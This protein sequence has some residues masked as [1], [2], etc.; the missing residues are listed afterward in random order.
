MVGEQQR[1]EGLKIGTQQPGIA[2]ALFTGREMPKN[3]AFCEE[4]H[5]SENCAN[6][7][8]VNEHKTV[9][10]KEARC[11]SYL[12]KGHRSFKYMLKVDCEI[13]KYKHHCT[14]RPTL[15]TSK[16]VTPQPSAPSYALH[17]ALQDRP[18]KPLDPILISLGPFK[19]RKQYEEG[20]KTQ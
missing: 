20:H 12:R 1:I 3:F 13:C 16:E 9:F 14:I 4:E 7:K 8:G 2:S 18:S 11:F 6:V 15:P 5:L 10:I 17:R 19:K